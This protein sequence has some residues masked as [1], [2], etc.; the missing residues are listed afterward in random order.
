[1][2]NDPDNIDQLTSDAAGKFDFHWRNYSRKEIDAMC[3]SEKNS[4]LA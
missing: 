4:K 2:S 3:I 1:M